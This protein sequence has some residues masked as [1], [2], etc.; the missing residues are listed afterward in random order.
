M[1]KKY[2][3]RKVRGGYW[4]NTGEHETIKGLQN[5]GYFR[6]ID[7]ESIWFRIKTFT[8]YALELQDEK[9]KNSI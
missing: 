3:W 2:G 5:H 7:I 6:E 9:F 1:F 8:V 4:S